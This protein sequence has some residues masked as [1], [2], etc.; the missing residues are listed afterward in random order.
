[1]SEVRLYVESRLCR[2]AGNRSVVSDAQQDPPTYRVR[3]RRHSRSELRC[4]GQVALAL[5]QEILSVID[6]PTDCLLS[7]IRQREAA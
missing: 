1:M 4:V 5:N 6:E 7:R 3:K 2:I